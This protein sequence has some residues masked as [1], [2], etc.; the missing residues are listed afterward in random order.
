[1]DFVMTVWTLLLPYRMKL[2]LAKLSWT[3]SFLDSSGFDKSMYLRTYV[4]QKSVFLQTKIITSMLPC[5]FLSGY[6][7]T[8]INDSL[9]SRGRGKAISLA[10][11][12]H[13]FFSSLFYAS[14][15]IMYVMLLI[16]GV[17]WMSC[18]VWID[19]AMNE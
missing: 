5:F 11:L 7:F 18:Y 16:L 9:D 10:L 15:K 12:Y 6:S 4:C 1:M 8:N 14:Y 19:T 17:N 13:L 3:A 2:C